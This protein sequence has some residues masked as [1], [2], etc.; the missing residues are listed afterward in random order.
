MLLSTLDEVMAELS[1]VGDET[2]RRILRKHGAQ[3]PCFGVRIENLKFILK[4][5]QA[6]HDLAMK[7]FASG[8]FDAMYLAGLMMDGATMSREELQAWCQTNYGSSISSYTV[9]WC[10]AESRFGFELALEWIESDREFV[11]VSGWN[12]LGSILLITEDAQ[13]DITS[14]RT[15]L[16]GLPSR[17]RT[18]QNRVKEAMNGYVI[19]AGSAV[20]ALTADALVVADQLGRVVVDVG[21]TACKIP[22]ARASIEKVQLKGRIGHKKKTAKC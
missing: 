15:L 7:L 2:I 3:E 10:A 11:A 18:A 4:Q 5:S 8:N 6:S 1:R 13:L 14:Y 9:P 19:A 12:T 21:D 16:Q 17:I 22:D 20:T